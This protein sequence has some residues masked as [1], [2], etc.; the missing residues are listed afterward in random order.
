MKI[1]LDD[2]FSPVIQLA[3]AYHVVVVQPSVP[4][5]TLGELVAPVEK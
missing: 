1:K 3:T 2:E 4:A 5:K